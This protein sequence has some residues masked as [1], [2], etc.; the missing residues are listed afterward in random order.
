MFVG[1]LEL[2]RVKNF[3][4]DHLLVGR[5]DYSSIFILFYFIF[6]VV[7]SKASNGSQICSVL[8]YRGTAQPLNYQETLLSAI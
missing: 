4:L 5:E 6:L 3:L 7:L 2:T 1:I 8:P